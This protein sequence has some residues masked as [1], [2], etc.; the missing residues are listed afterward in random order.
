[1]FNLSIKNLKEG[2]I[3]IIY[4][5]NITNTNTVLQDFNQRRPQL[6]FTMKLE[7]NQTIFLDLSNLRHDNERYFNIYSKTTYTN[8]TVPL[9]SSHPFDP[10]FA[11][12]QFLYKI[13]STLDTAMFRATSCTVFLSSFFC[14]KN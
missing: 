14:S 13:S 10:K 9:N 11:I 4:D 5:H 8:T 1:V 2:D 7:N 6:E 12:S 3:M